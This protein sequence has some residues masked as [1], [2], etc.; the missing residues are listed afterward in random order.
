[1]L[2]IRPD[3]SKKKPDHN[4]DKPCRSDGYL[5]TLRS[6]VLLLVSAGVAVLGVHDPRW[7]AAVLC[8]VTVLAYLANVIKLCA[9][10]AAVS[11]RRTPGA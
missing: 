10:R 9:R 6:F 8:G 7:G 3:H 2:H 11:P 5:L 4:K 1:M